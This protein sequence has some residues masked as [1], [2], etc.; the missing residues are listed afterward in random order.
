MAQTLSQPIE[1]GV[2]LGSP[3]DV[4]V[5]SRSPRRPV[6]DI[7]SKGLG[8]NDIAHDLFDDV[9]SAEFMLDGINSPRESVFSLNRNDNRRRSNASQDSIDP[10]DSS[11]VEF[12]LDELLEIEVCQIDDLI[13][14]AKFH[15]N[16]DAQHVRYVTL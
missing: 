6:M 7:S 12:F 1:F 16:S 13:S 10:I 14:I 11:A 8:S 3:A 2:S 5:P 4:S 9:S 15:D